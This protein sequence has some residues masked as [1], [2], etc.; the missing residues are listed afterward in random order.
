[1]QA[2]DKGDLGGRLERERSQGK[3]LASRLRRGGR[4]QKSVWGGSALDWV[5]SQQQQQQQQLG[6]P[7]PLVLLVLVSLHQR[8]VAARPIGDFR[9]WPWER[10]LRGL[11]GIPRRS[12]SLSFEVAVRCT[13][14]YAMPSPCNIVAATVHPKILPP[15]A[16][17]AR[18]LI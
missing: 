17:D 3:I 4:L 18:N 8:R 11:R 16:L 6:T 2:I 5:H 14:C 1:M 7:V 10:G 9:S 12:S 15:P 13:V